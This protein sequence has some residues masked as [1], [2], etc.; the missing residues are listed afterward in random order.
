[1]Q[2]VA[3]VQRDISSSDRRLHLV[4]EISVGFPLCSSGDKMRLSTTESHFQVTD[5][6]QTTESSFL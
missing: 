3:A 6:M 5:S 1:M 4:I 2:S